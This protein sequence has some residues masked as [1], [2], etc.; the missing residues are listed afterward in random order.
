MY[1]QTIKLKDNEL[2]AKINVETGEVKDV[3]HKKNNIPEGKSKLNYDNFSII[4]NDMLKVLLEECSTT[5]IKIILH[6]IYMSNFNSNSL[7]PL[8]NET[9]NSEL[10][11]VFNINDKTVKTVFEKLK[12]LG[13]YLQLNITEIDGA[14]EY[15]VLNPYISWKGKLKSDSL[16]LTFKNTRIVKLMN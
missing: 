8:N 10:S 5:E 4:N 13:V 15:W 16:F 6:M 1:T 12:F 9:S 3:D 14:K 2:P 11:R 7:T